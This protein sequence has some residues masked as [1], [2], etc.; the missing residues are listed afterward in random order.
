MLL[1]V[2]PPLAEAEAAAL[3]WE[4]KDFREEGI[5]SLASVLIEGGRLTTG[6]NCRGVPAG[7]TGR[8]GQGEVPGRPG[9]Q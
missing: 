9:S 2:A 6:R 7:V 5:S 1:V 8:R 4:I 3:S